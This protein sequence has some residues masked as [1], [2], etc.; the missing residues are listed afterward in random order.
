MVGLVMVGRRHCFPSFKDLAMTPTTYMVFSDSNCYCYSSD[1]SSSSLVIPCRLCQYPAS[2]LPRHEW[3]VAESA[4]G[5][6]ATAG[7]PIE[8]ANTTA[9]A[10][11]CIPVSIE[12][13]R[14]VISEKRRPHF[15]TM[16]PTKKPMQ[17]RDTTDNTIGRINDDDCKNMAA[18]WETTPPQIKLTNKTDANGVKR[19]TRLARVGAF[20]LTTIPN[21]TGK[22]TTR[23]V[24]SQRAHPETS[25]VLPTKS[26]TNKGVTIDARMVEHDVKRT[27]RATSA[28]AIND[29]RL[30]AVPPGEQP[31][32]HNP[33]NKDAPWDPEL[34]SSLR[35]ITK[36]DSGMMMNWQSTPAG[37]AAKSRPKT[38]VKSSFSNVKPVAHM[39]LANIHE[40]KVPRF[41]HINVVGC[42][43]PKMADPRTKNG[44]ADVKRDKMLSSLLGFVVS[45]SPVD[46]DS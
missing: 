31:T 13:V 8:R 27:E 38:F 32:R 10:E 21:M 26:F 16:Y 19:D 35:P 5:K 20:A 18:F 12:I 11:F 39:T 40:I 36:A 9:K 41:V 23:A 2:I 6:L 15:G 28:F 24:A 7:A 43:N 4:P 33:R 37:T 14:L 42:N 46:S 25:M 30:D 3:T 17:W 34:S 44:K 22:R 1:E 45:S 29:T